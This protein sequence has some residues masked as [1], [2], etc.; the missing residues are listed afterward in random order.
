MREAHAR[1]FSLPSLFAEFPSEFRPRDAVVLAGEGA[2]ST[3]HRD[4]FDWVG[5]SL[6]L[7][8]TKVWR[9]IVPKDRESPR[10]R[11]LVA[12]ETRSSSCLADLEAALGTYPVSSAAWGTMMVCCVP[13]VVTG[14]AC[15]AGASLL[16]TLNLKSNA[17]RLRDQA[18]PAPKPRST[19]AEI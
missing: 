10:R 7:A 3:L 19:S 12:D 9:F 4:P 8:G 1:A 11:S 17:P 6:N 2:T 13:A 16:E 14:I 15:A 18:R 5:T